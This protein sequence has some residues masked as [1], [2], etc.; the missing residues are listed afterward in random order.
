MAFSSAGS[1][2]YTEH[3]DNKV[4]YAVTSV[5]LASYTLIALRTGL[6]WAYT[7]D[8]APSRD[9][10]RRYIAKR[11]EEC[12]SCVYFRLCVN[13]FMLFFFCTSTLLQCLVFF[14]L[15][16]FIYCNVVEAFCVLRLSCVPL[17]VVF[18][19]RKWNYFP[20]FSTVHL[21]T[22]TRGVGR[23]EKLFCN[24][25]VYCCRCKISRIEIYETVWPRTE[26]LFCVGVERW[27]EISGR[28]EAVHLHVQ[29]RSVMCMHAVRSWL[30][31]RSSQSRLCIWN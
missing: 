9:R 3:R 15:L 24:V 2:Q 27:F 21:H 19:T 29:S 28:R 14:T 7:I 25:R 8:K 30:E 23:K 1:V 10:R 11:M 18:C 6:R 22:S 31:W 16:L 4:D 26:C 13:I 20:F 17:R 12:K 5:E